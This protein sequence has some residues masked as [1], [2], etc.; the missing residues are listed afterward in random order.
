MKFFIKDFFSKYYQIRRELLIWSQLLKKF[1]IENFI[2][3][4]V[5]VRSQKYNFEMNYIQDSLVRGCSY[6]GE[7]ARLGGLARLGQSR[8]L[9]E[10]LIKI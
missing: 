9:Q 5:I 10:T 3:Y 4:S 2:F 7:L 1:L 6:G 8:L